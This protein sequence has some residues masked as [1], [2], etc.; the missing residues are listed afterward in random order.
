[1]FSGRIYEARRKVD[2][3][4]LV[5]LLETLT[6]EYKRLNPPTAPPRGVS[7]PTI[8]VKAILRMTDDAEITTKG[9]QLLRS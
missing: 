6:A 8:I 4:M 9:I 2:D 3:H 5:A 7:I 1:M